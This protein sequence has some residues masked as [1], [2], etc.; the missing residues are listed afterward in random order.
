MKVELCGVTKK[1]GRTCAL[2]EVQL[3][4]PPG[5]IVALVGLNG[6][7]K[8]TLLHVMAGIAALSDGSIL[9]DGEKFGRGRLDLRRRL[10]FLPDFPAFLPGHTPLQ[11]IAMA[12]H[13][14]GR[15][16]EPGIEERVVA[17]LR[18]FALLPLADM[19]LE[20]LSRGQ[21]YKAELVSL[22][23]VNPELWLIDEPF[24]SGMDPLGLRALRERVRA[25][26]AEGRTIIYTTQILPM[27]E[28]F[29]DLVCV[30]DR[31]ALAAFDTAAEIRTRGAATGNLEAL[32][33]QLAEESGA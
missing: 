4:L 6:A 27:A 24:A 19:P 30:L 10:S 20:Y 31:G 33:A 16:E 22:M 18:E 15:E 29:S 13:L 2:R 12:L 26:A 8:S 7:G 14:Y 21:A 28:S 5:R 23:A 17:L 32:F 1:Y 9:Y 25:A 3:T 11:H